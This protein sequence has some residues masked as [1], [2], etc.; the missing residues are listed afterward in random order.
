MHGDVFR[1]ATIVCVLKA[2][3][4]GAAERGMWGHRGVVCEGSEP[5]VCVVQVSGP[6]VRDMYG[7][8]MSR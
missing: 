5:C 8:A 6:G 3:V 2:R 4:A 7:M 1:Y